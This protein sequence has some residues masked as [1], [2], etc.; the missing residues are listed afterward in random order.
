M[1]YLF[2]RSG[3][4]NYWIRLLSPDKRIEKSLAAC[5]TEVYSMI[6]NDGFAGSNCHRTLGRIQR[7]LL[8]SVSRLRPAILGCI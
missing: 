1:K 2:Q 3:S 5:R 7:A 4:Q 6:A 8:R